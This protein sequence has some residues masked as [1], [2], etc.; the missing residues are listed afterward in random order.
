MNE[1]SSTCVSLDRIPSINTWKVELNRTLFESSHFILAVYD[2][3]TYVCHIACKSTLET[4]EFSFF[5]NCLTINHGIVIM[6]AHLV[7][8]SMIC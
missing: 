2:G 1:P 5:N 3:R 4:V 8:S 6:G 7:T